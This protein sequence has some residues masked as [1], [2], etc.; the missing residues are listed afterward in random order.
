MREYALP[1]QGM[2][3]ILLN[4]PVL[5]HVLE[6]NLST[7]EIVNKG[8]SS[9]LAHLPRTHRI[10][11]AW[12][13]EQV[14]SSDVFLKHCPSAEQKGDS[15]AKALD[16]VKHSEAL[17]TLGIRALINSGAAAFGHPGLCC[18]TIPFPRNPKGEDGTPHLSMQLEGGEIE[19][20]APSS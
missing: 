9:R 14:A 16:K 11:V 2:W 17:H 5:L 7:I 8:Y 1:I 20:H 13:A 19:F 12:T 4:R 15:F 10:S 18:F 3:S 6:D